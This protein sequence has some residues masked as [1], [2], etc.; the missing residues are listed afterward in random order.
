VLHVP[1]FQYDGLGGVIGTL[2][3]VRYP[4]QDGVVRRE[5]RVSGGLTGILSRQLSVVGHQLSAVGRQLKT[6]AVIQDRQ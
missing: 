4:V 6:R 2:G 5:S 3:R 1:Y